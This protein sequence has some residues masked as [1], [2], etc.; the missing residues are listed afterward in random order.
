MR[1]V[2]GGGRSEGIENLEKDQ[3]HHLYHIAWGKGHRTKG[4]VGYLKNVDAHHK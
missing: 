2:N 1:H 3:P 4:I